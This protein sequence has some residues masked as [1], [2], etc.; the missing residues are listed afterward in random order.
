MGEPVASALSGYIRQGFL[1]EMAMTP[2]G[3]EEKFPVGMIV[4]AH[5]LSK[6]NSLNSFNGKIGKVCGYTSLNGKYVCVSFNDLG[7]KAVKPENLKFV[8]RAS[9]D[10]AQDRWAKTKADWEAKIEE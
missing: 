9:G 6:T 2:E 3:V 5:S 4:E 10:T 1:D 8:E 7:I